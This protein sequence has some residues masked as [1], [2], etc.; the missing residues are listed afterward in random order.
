MNRDDLLRLCGALALGSSRTVL[1]AE[2]AA[3]L[4]RSE[5]PDQWT[6]AAELQGILSM[7]G[8]FDVMED[9]STGRITVKRQL[10]AFSGDAV[11][12]G[13]FPNRM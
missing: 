5:R 6:I 13:S 3:A 1:L 4:P 2:I 7:I 12:N 10:P 11:G 9:R 8:E